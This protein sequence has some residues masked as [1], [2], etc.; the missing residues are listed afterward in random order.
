MTQEE[1]EHDAM[2][3]SLQC[4]REE[5]TAYEA[6]GEKR[7]FALFGL[8]FMHLS[9]A[10]HNI[11]TALI[12]HANYYTGRCDPGILALAYETGRHRRTAMKAI[13]ELE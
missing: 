10:A 13:K 12:W 6:P 2:V 5:P 4:R 1:Y 11:G 9:G 7:Y 8:G 3:D